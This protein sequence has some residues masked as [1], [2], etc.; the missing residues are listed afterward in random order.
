MNFNVLRPPAAFVRKPDGKKPLPAQSCVELEA[1]AFATT[2]VVSVEF[3]LGKRFIAT[4]KGDFP[5]T[6]S[7]TPD[8][9]DIGEH[10]IRARVVDAFGIQR[11]S[12][13]VLIRI[14]RPK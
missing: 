8:M 14:E 6:A 7:W 3:Y 1:N 13:P 5:Y 10:K 2:T 4:A 9:S 11:D 12:N